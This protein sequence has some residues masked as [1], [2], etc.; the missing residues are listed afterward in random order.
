MTAESE[1]IMMYPYQLSKA[2]ADQRIH[3]MLVAAEHRELMGSARSHS[4]KLAEP[5]APRSVVTAQIASPSGAGP[6]GCSA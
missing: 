6:M 2:L 3:D 5:S 1:E 4:R